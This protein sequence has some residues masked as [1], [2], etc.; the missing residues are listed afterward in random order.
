MTQQ[1]EGARAD[2]DLVNTGDDFRF[3]L[4]FAI[5]AI[6]SLIAGLA[7]LAYKYKQSLERSA[8]KKGKK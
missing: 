2:A 5:L 4:L 3:L 7:L 8:M 1:Q 6:G